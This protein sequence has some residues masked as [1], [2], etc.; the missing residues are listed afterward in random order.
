MNVVVGVDQVRIVP[1][2][3]T[4]CGIGGPLVR[5]PGTRQAKVTGRTSVAVSG[6]AGTGG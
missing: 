5:A 1:I 3:L 4:H 6:N 2:A